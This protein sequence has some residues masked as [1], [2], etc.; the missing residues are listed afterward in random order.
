MECTSGGLNLLEEVRCCS[1][2]GASYNN[3][4]I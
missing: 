2:L 3:I 1:D 4:Y